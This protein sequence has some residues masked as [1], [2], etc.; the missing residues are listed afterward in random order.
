MLNSKVT[1]TGLPVVL[2]HGFCEDLSLWENLTENLKLHYKVISID[3]PGFGKSDPID[4]DFTIENVASILH[5]TITNELQIDK[6]I[7]IGHSLGGYVSLALADMYPRSI[8]ALGLINSTSFAD[9]E[10]KKAIRNKTVEFINKHGVAK[11]LEGFVSNLFTPSNQ[12]VLSKEM[13]KVLNMGINLPNNTVTR[14]MKAMRDRPDRSFLLK[15]SNH[16]L[17]IGGREDQHVSFS[18]IEKQLSLLKIPKNGLIFDKVGHMSMFEATNALQN[19][20][21]SFLLSVKKMENG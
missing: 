2:L 17:F 16:F 14:Y 4:G 13:N 11:F 6:Y 10:E 19:A 20:I 9:S 15:Q 12:K 3:L 18:D 21:N 8:L 5:D 1:G 7:V